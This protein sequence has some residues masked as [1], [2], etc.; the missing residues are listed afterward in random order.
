MGLT[1]EANSLLVRL[2]ERHP[3]EFGKIVQK[4]LALTFQELGFELIEERAVQGVDIDVIRQD[5]GE[6]FSFEVKTSQGREVH[7]GSKDIEGLRSRQVDGYDTYF[8]VLCMPFCFSD[9]WIIFSS[10]GIKEGNYNAVRLVGK[11]FRELSE[12]INGAFP[13]VL[14]KVGEELIS[15]PGG[16]ALRYLKEKLGI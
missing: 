13:L 2:H 1:L 5:T 10:R 12:E 6:R 8:A 15:R 4:L 9:G 16:T 14:K 3:S 11:R 7:I